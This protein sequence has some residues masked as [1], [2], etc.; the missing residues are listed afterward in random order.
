[1]AKIEW[2][3]V[4]IGR[5]AHILDRLYIMGIYK[6]FKDFQNFQ[7]FTKNPNVLA[8]D[9]TEKCLFMAKTDG[10]TVFLSHEVYITDRLYLIVMYINSYEL[11]KYKFW[12]KI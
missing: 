2:N 6:F 5:E 1:M 10:N 9:F 11:K 4:S 8:C 3:F 12:L 7:I